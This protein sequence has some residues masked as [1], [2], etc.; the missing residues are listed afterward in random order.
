MIKKLKRQS[1]ATLGL[2]QEND[3]E[4]MINGSD[5]EAGCAIWTKRQTCEQRTHT[6]EMYNSQNTCGRII[7]VFTP[8]EQALPQESEAK[9]LKQ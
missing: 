6:G 3:E 4:K 8:W 5:A 1:S 9:K 7:C 2:V